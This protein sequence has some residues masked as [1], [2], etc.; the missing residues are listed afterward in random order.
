MLNKKF[1]TLALMLVCAL[2]SLTAQTRNVK[3]TVV[4]GADKEPVIGA[5]V[6]VAGTTTGAISDMD[7]VFNIQAEADAVLE[8]SYIGFVSQSIKLNG[9]TVI[10][11]VLREDARMLEQVVVTGYTTQRRADLTGAVSV[12]DVTEALKAPENNAIKSLQGRVPGMNIAYDGNPGG[13]SSVTIRGVSNFSGY[14]NPLY[15]IDG[16]PTQGGMHELSPGDIESIQV[17]KDAASASIYGS[18]AANGVIVITTKQGKEGKVKVN[19]DASL[20]T[21]FYHNRVEMLNSKEYGQAMW[22]AIVNNGMDPNM[23]NPIGYQYDWAYDANGNAMLNGMRVPKYIDKAGKMLASETDW[24]DEVSR[25]GLAQ[26]YNLSIGGGG[27]NLRSQFSMNYYD[28]QGTLVDTYFKRFS[29]RLNTTYTLAGGKVVVG[30]NF[31]VNRTQEVEANTEDVLSQAL[32]SHPLVPV[33]MNDGN[34]GG[35]SA[36]MNDRHNPVR[37][38]NAGKDNPYTYWRLF[39]NAFAEVK[40]L[41]GLRLKTS[42]GLDYGNFYKRILRK[43]FISGEKWDEDLNYAELQQRHWM[44]WTWSNTAHYDLHFGLNHL[45]ILAGVEVSKENNVE[46]AA[47]KEGF[48]LETNDFMWPDAGVGTALSYGYS[49][50]YSLLS[51]FG[52]LNYSFADRYLLSAT[53]RYDGSSRFGKNNKYGLFP[54]FSAGWRIREEAFMES[55]RD[56][57]SDLKLRL[58]MGQTGNQGSISSDA[59]YALYLTAYDGGGDGGGSNGTA[60]DIAGKGSGLLSSG[61]RKNRSGNDDLKWETTTQTNIGLDF[62][63]FNQKLYGSLDYYF[64]ETKDLLITV[65]YPAAAGEGSYHYANAGRMQNKGLELL[66]GYRGKTAFGLNYDF[67]GTI[68]GNR[69]KVVELPESMINSFGGNGDDDTILGRSIYSQYGYVAD[70]IFK[71][72]EEVDNHPEQSG[73]GLGRIRYKNMNTDNVIDADDRTWIGTTEP[74]FEYGLNIN[75]EYKGFDLSMFLQ[76]ICGGV[77]YNSLKKDTDFWSVSQTGS[78]KGRRLLDAWSPTNPGSNIPAL[79]YTDDNWEDRFSTYFLE[80]RSFLK[81]RNLQLGYTLPAGA[82]QKLKLEKLRF[83]VSGQNLFMLKSKSYT[84][85]DP[86]NPGWGYPIPMTCTVGVNL[87][88]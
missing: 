66:L 45:D 76:G 68:S 44:K 84:G 2:G 81:L 33:H 23:V 62:G 83:Y 36:G 72:Q 34:W 88:F 41:E 51:Y 75:L 64:K 31:S 53:V 1:I 69:N 6:I 85:V 77:V 47:Y 46:F 17:L 25:T 10:E 27:E 61:F 57:L 7:G 9:R 40:P 49:T 30:E 24:F 13:K 19:F 71:T 56:V 82:V 65:Y 86:E 79:S 42:V 5:N 59:I 74:D 70:G 4:T 21:S 32:Q 37:L 43:S 11:V 18:R 29:A 58:A 87:A 35:P 15:I 3:G 78:N 16:V 73:K 55:T 54:S 52:K 50:A 22:Q 80:N 14:T 28:N 67:T 48:E 60:Y 63:F 38:L 20:T 8:I 26:N 39:G 12:V